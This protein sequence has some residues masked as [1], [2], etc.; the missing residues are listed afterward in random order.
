MSL[1]QYFSS[2]VILR[3]TP[4]DPRL[5]LSG[6][7]CSQSE[8]GEDFSPHSHQ[9]DSNAPS[10]DSE[11]GHQANA[12]NKHHMGRLTWN[13]SFAN[14]L[15]ETDGSF[16]D[17]SMLPCRSRSTDHWDT[18]NYYPH[19]EAIGSPW[20]T[21]QGVSFF[22]NNLGEEQGSGLL[23]EPPVSAP[24][25]LEVTRRYTEPQLPL[26]QLHGS[27]FIKPIDGASF[28]M[29]NITL[30]VITEES[31][32]EIMKERFFVST[33]PSPLSVEIPSRLSDE[34]PDYRKYSLPESM[35]DRSS[36]STSQ[37]TDFPETVSP[38]SLQC[39]TDHDG[40]MHKVDT[41][42]RKLLVWRP[43]EP[44][45]TMSSWEVCPAMCELQHQYTHTHL[46]D[47]PQAT[48]ANGNTMIL[49]DTMPN[50]EGL[51]S[52]LAESPSAVEP[53]NFDP[54]LPNQDT[55]ESF[56]GI[57]NPSSPLEKSA[58][59]HGCFD[60][61]GSMQFSSVKAEDSSH[62][63]SFQNAAPYPT[64]EAS[65]PTSPKD[66]RV[67]KIYGCNICPFQ[68]SGKFEN[69][70]AYLRKHIKTHTNPQVKCCWC[71]KYFT[72]QDNATAHAYRAHSDMMPRAVKRSV[73][74]EENEG[75]E[76]S[77]TKKYHST[78]SPRLSKRRK[79]SSS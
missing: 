63:V 59:P 79:M 35:T 33:V 19:I 38:K 44:D 13:Q 10:C 45:F 43:C 53:A 12:Y 49:P 65:S 60:G 64:P 3:L 22:K 30:P 7:R 67:S 77:P 54:Q 70:A 34:C 72:R 17:N 40:A 37:F 51:F 15:K 58:A 6:W 9:G 16:L 62:A 4:L 66:S 29:G 36:A 20:M 71:E 56:L 47:Y 55:E 52:L 78:K 5:E 61:T 73:S 57:T 46:Y 14:G 31:P 48:F 32:D 68:P 8:C 75:E 18:Y 1:L 27:K 69:H 23:I 28:N 11:A 25:S 26:N 39:N 74:A 2:N 41:D 76:T 21:T 42:S 24:S 50:V